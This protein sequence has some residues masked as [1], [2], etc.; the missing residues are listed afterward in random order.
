MT[1]GRR[2]RGSRLS[3]ACWVLRHTLPA[4]ERIGVLSDL[5]EAMRSKFPR[6]GWRA[7]L[8][9]W[10][11][12]VSFSTRFLAE[13]V[14][15]RETKRESDSSTQRDRKER[16]MGESLKDVT[17]AIRQLV[18]RPGFTV[19]VV[20]T[21]ALGIGPNTAI[22]SVV[23]GV[24]LT[25]LP[26]R[27]PDRLNLIRVDLSGLEQHP[28]IAR[29][30]IVDFR[31]QSELLEDVGAVTREFTGSLGGEGDMEAALVASV[32][33]NL[34]PLLG[35]DPILGRHF[36]AEE[37][38]RGREPVA[39]ISH[40]LWHRRF[41]G[42]PDIIGRTVEMNGN[43]RPIVGVMPEGFQLLLGPGTSLSPNVDLWLPMVVDRED[44]GFWAYRAIAR[45]APGAT[46]AQAQAEVDAIGERL[47]E[48]HAFA[49]ENSGIRY[50]LHPLHA[51]LVQNVRPAI[52]TLL[53]AVGL[54]L[55]IACTNAASLLL[56]RTKARE[57]ELALRAA[58]G[59]GRGRIMRQ[60]VVESVVLALLAGGVGLL[61]GTLGLETLLSL[62]PGN[63]PRPG[64]IGLDGRVLGFTLGASFLASMLFGL[65]PAWQ[66]S[67]PDVQGALREVHR[68]GGSVRGHTRNALVIAEIAFSL[69]LL[70]GAGLLI[71]TF[72][73]LRQVNLGYD[74]ESV[75]T[76]QAPID[77]Q[78]FDTPESR[79]AVYRRLRE[80]V[81]ALPGVRSVGGISLVPLGNQGLM[82][83]YSYDGALDTDWNGLSAD[84]RFVLP[85]YFEAMGVR[86][87]SGR[88]LGDE[89]NETLRA[90]ALVDETLARQAWPDGD[91][92]GKRLGIGLGTA[93]EED[94]VEVVGVVEHGRIINVRE[95]VR[96][97]IYLPYR[98]GPGPN[99]TLAIRTDSDP[100]PLIASIRREVDAVGT[101]RAVNAVRTMDAYVSAAM[102]G[103]RFTLIL[104][105]ILASIALVLS[106]VGIYSVITY[107]ARQRSH[108][109]GIRIALGAQRSDI[110]RMN[111]KE[112]LVLASAGVPIGLGGAFF[113]SRFIEN[114]LYGVASTDPVTFVGIPILLI[115][116]ALLASYLPARRAS[117]V[118][119]VVA[120]RSE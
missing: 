28:G 63:L 18:K 61:L 74:P 67:K 33:P 94:E 96:P 2:K 70:I 101:G 69:M 103:T 86:L 50:Y 43:S 98:A 99:M 120:L 38:V 45:L 64:E 95:K 40:G 27:D 20:L 53:G 56:A 52:L 54:V 11:Q 8:W 62:Q 26:Y 16:T 31:E 41:G 21:L 17:L 23:N 81:G 34:F 118:D 3:A 42:D 83:S 80:Q 35:I 65:I 13:R 59:A 92:V 15:E 75:V 44:R 30:E 47:V 88:F 25:P 10:L 24:L 102:G 9:F 113:L 108:E 29:A 91:A 112:G 115:L 7:T 37:E 51:D 36:T 58:L 106:S 39:I 14:R 71:R 4:D 77:I 109:T 107:L 32:T 85:G 76:F 22:F 66:A 5:D 111:V 82:A 117:H 1:S 55:L 87:L 93:L 97:Q 68:H 49:Y 84:Y 6:G 116:V 48:E 72:N 57:K 79:V 46:L 78:Q 119:P 89:D 19:A 100:L 104:M 90:V 12:T 114:L 73:S 105:G 110:V 60:V